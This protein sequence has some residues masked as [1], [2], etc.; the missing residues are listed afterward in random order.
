ML[1]GMRIRFTNKRL[2]A[3]AELL[4]LLFL[5][6]LPAMILLAILAT[7]NVARKSSLEELI[8]KPITWK[9]YLTAGD[10]IRVCEGAQ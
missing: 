3:W 5:L 7:Y 6:G 2:K 9:Q 8:G 10:K 1:I 4:R